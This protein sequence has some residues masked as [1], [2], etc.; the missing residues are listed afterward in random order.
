MPKEFGRHRDPN[1]PARSAR[2]I[3][4][5]GSCSN[6]ARLRAGNPGK[7]AER[8]QEAAAISCLTSSAQP[9]VGKLSS[10]GSRSSTHRFGVTNGS[11]G[12]AT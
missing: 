3:T 1:V 10:S 4:T 6:S 12:S 2:G 7:S 5:T 9:L 11:E 8:P